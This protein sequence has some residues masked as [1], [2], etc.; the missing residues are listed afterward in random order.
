MSDLERLQQLLLQ[1]AAPCMVGVKAANLIAWPGENKPLLAALKAI[2]EDLSA[3]GLAYRLLP[4]R[5]KRLLLFL[6]RP[7]DLQACLAKPACRA[8]LRRFA[9]PDLADI[10]AQLKHLAQRLQSYNLD[11]GKAKDS[12][13]HE[14]GLFLD[15]P[16]AEVEAFMAG[17]TAQAVIGSWK[18][19]CDPECA[20]CRFAQFKLAQERLEALYAKGQWAALCQTQWTEVMAC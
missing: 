14:I 16:P 3:Q 1:H 17:E 15:Y 10:S 11:G 12:Y 9:Y 6:Y 2:R 7:Q 19:F 8:C 18:V 13:P 20:R 4:G 5:K